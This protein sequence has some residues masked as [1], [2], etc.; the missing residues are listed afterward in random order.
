MST[1]AELKAARGVAIDAL[2]TLTKDAKA[3]ARKEAEIKELDGEI[4]R[5]LA[6]Q[7]AAA[8]LAR[9]TGTDGGPQGDQDPNKF[10]N[11]GEFLRSVVRFQTGRGM[12]KRLEA[13]SRAPTG[14]GETDPSGG[15]FPIPPDFSTDILTKVYDMGEL[16][17]RVRRVQIS[18]TSNSIKLPGI[19]ETS[20]V[21]GSRWGGVQAYWVAEGDSVTAAKPKFRVIELDLKKLMAVWYITDELLNDAPALASIAN[22]AF[23]EELTFMLEDAIWEGT[24]SGQPQGILN[25]ACAISVAKE[26]GQA[27]ATLLYQNLLKMWSRMWARSRFEAVWFIQQDV[28]PQLYAL[29]SVIGT[30]GVPVYMP[31][32]GISSAP[33]AT[34]FGRPVIPIEY[35]STLGTV[36]DIVLADM[37]Q[38]VVADKNTMEQ[39]TSIHVQFLT[40]QTAFRLTY[41]ADGQPIW[42]SALTPFKGTNTRSP[43]VTLA[44]R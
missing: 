9:P 18:P 16:L 8:R 44:A 21:T 39:A 11:I 33:Y 19:D 27:A 40:D 22:Q 43:F 20:R 4:E 32:G 5:T 41:R 37:S 10:K 31:P 26:T 12:D 15:G 23:S 38:Y 34:L 17:K 24:G 30:A 25:A 13:V 36:G 14:M 3:F 2:A 7:A 42:N 35:A 29:N 1:L 28:E 6:A